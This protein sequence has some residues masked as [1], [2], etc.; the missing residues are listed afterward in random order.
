M[1]V[2][3][4]DYGTP[5]SAAAATV[6][7][8]IDGKAVTVPEGTS[9]MRA[10]MEAGTEIPKLCATDRLDAFGLT[11][12]PRHMVD[13]IRPLHR[14]VLGHVTSVVVV[15][16]SFSARAP[17]GA[18]V[19]SALVRGRAFVDGGRPYSGWMED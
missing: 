10:A 7:L 17:D 19:R 18:R 13:Q 11:V 5:R 8:V 6:S 12:L 15:G 3:E 1:L 4:I 14:V 16:T 9:I 2:E